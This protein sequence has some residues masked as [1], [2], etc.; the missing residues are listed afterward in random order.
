MGGSAGDIGR[1]FHYRSAPIYLLTTAVAILFGADIFIGLLEEAGVSGWSKYQQLAGFRLALLAAVLGGAR[2]LYRTLESL[3][4]GKVGADL[5]LTIA[6]LAAI[7]LGEHSTAALVV[8]IALC[9]ESIEGYTIDRAQ[10]AIRSVFNLCPPTARVLIDGRET[11][12]PIGEVEVGHTVVVRPGERVPVDGAVSSGDSSVDESALTGESLP[13]EKETGASVFAGT[14]NQFGSLEIEATKVGEDTTLARVVQ[15][16]AEATE[17]KAPLERAADR[18]ARLFLPVVLGVAVLTLIGWRISTG[19]W[20]PGFLPAL[21]VLVVACPC[22]LILATPSAV[23]AAMAWLARSGVVVKG[24][25]AME[26]L[27]Q[28][29]TFAFDK[30]GTLTK[31]ELQLGRVL[32]V[33]PLDETELLRTAAIAERRSEHLIARLICRE[34]EARGCVLPGVYEFESLPGCG[35]VAQVTPDD[36]GDWAAELAIDS[37][38]AEAAPSVPSPLGGEAGRRP[39]EGVAESE[40]A[41]E[42]QFAPPPHPPFGHPLPRGERGQDEGR[43]AGPD[44]ARSTGRTLALVVGNRRLFERLGIDLP[45]FLDA[46]LTE[47]DEAGQSSLIIAVQG[48]VLGVIG[49]RD[50]VRESAKDVLTELRVSGIENFAVLT[51]DREAPAKQLAEELPGFAAVE[52]GLLPADKSAW[53]ETQIGAGRRVAMV[54]DGVNDAPALATATVGIALG[55]VGSDIA[56]EAGDLVLMGDPLKPL[57]GLLRLSR[58]LVRTIRQSIFLFAFGMNGVGMILGATGILT[59]PA[60]AVFHEIASLAVMLNALRLL[61]FER[62]EVTRL[63]RVSNWFGSSVEWLATALSPTQLV[64]R[65]LAHWATLVRLGVAGVGLAWFLSNAVLVGSDEQAVV[66]RFGKYEA[67]LDAGLHWRWPAPFEEVR[68]ERVYEIRTIEIGFRSQSVPLE[69]D[70]PPAAIEWT[71]AHSGQAEDDVAEEALMLTGEEMPVELTAEVQ[72]RISN[73]REFAFASREPADLLRSVAESSLREVVAQISLNGTLTD[74]RPQ[75]ESRCLKKIAAEAERYGIGVEVIGVSLLDVHPPRQVVPSYRQVADA[76]ELQAQLK[77]EAEAYYART[78]LSAAGED[79]IRVLSDSVNANATGGESTTGAVTDWS[80]TN[81]LWQKLIA[82]TDDT[83]MRL[84]GEAASRL[85]IARQQATQKTTAATGSAARINSLVPLY[86]Q[87]PSLTGQHLYWQA[88]CRSLADRPLTVLDP[89]VT[90]R[91][92]VLLV[93]PDEFSAPSILQPM[94]QPSPEEGVLQEEAPRE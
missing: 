87:R 30:T 88:I 49:V 74:A 42:S 47:L 76:I 35:V 11:E 5:A 68:R 6:C 57:P 1:S 65:F 73:L 21:S 59:P 70:F 55:G 72:F 38:A 15:L 91:R 13:V 14:V 61:W 41:N 12:V 43:S 33:E 81:E 93:D 64:F 10:K 17:K 66:T 40:L 34:A 19:E 18:Y 63:G 53:V 52:A 9:G 78:V 69:G 62:W 86:L 37:A 8:F 79:A 16:V 67:T 90:G 22:P 26:R 7:V 32:P 23:M 89:G 29:D 92:H 58:A 3:F 36:L 46:Q 48:Q 2:I 45:E 44:A 94:L 71:S 24:S 28:V 82:E 56:A 83:S 20:R 39:D 84:S 75:I 25:A 51:G 85:M 27:A 4:D 77:N 31:G 54:G 60:A 50:T 80:L